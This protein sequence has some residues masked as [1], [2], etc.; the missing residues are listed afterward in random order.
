MMS[1]T[2]ALVAKACGIAVTGAAVAYAIIA[3]AATMRR[4]HSASRARR[5]DPPHVPRARSDFA[6]VTVLKPLCGAEP[7]LYECLRSFCAQTYPSFQIV[8][9]VRDADD[10]AVA[11]VRRLQREYP[12]RDLELVVDPTEHGSSLKVSNLIN[13]FRAARHGTLVVSDS[14]VR[15]PA[16]YLERVV[17]PLGDLSVGLVTCG[18]RGVASRG[19]WSQLLAAFVNGWFM[20]SVYLGDALGASD[21]VSGVTIALRRDT[22]ASVGGFE[23]IADQLADDHR[24]GELTRARGLATVLSDMTVETKIDERSALELIRH[25][26]RWLRT[27]RAVRPGGYAA[28]FITFPLPVAVIGTL[29]ASGSD[30]ALTMLAATVL[31]RLLLHF[32]GSRKGTAALGLWVIPV[33]DTLAFILWCWGFLSR[34]V[35]WRQAR[36][37]V[38]RDGTVQPIA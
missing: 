19:P 27:I 31:A 16:D 25:E 14:D 26:L 36:F 6:A 35:H 3:A 21:F 15:V 1:P 34:H 17:A 24:L 20:P 2:L 38:A 4:R 7:Q 8:F 18:Y 10:P 37:R 22:L 32:D 23:A 33:S 13:M 28:A 29:L 5:A 30:A 12:H 9:G 11:V